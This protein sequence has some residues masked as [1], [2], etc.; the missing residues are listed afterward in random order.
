MLTITKTIEEATTANGRYRAGGTDYMDRRR[1]GLV[2]GDIVDVAELE[3]LDQIQTDDDGRTLIGAMATIFSVTS[4]PHIQEKYAGLAVAAGG[5]ATPQIRLVGTIGG[6]M[7]QRTRCQYFRHHHLKCTKK[8]DPTCGGRK[9]YHPNGIIFD[10]GG[11][12]HP[13]PSTLGMAL[14]AYEAEIEVNGRDS[15]PIFDLY[16]DGSDIGKDHLL[17]DGELIT[18]IILPVPKEEKATYFR[19]TERERAEW[20]TVECVVRLMMDGDVIGK[21]YVAVGAVGP[22]PM[23]LPQVEAALVGKEATEENFMAAAALSAE[24]ATPLRD[25]GYKVTL[26]VNTIVETLLQAVK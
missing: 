22:V 6:N 11:C 14:M 19:A 15:R 3:G 24:G 21:A 25:T 16:G 20:A 2:S 18:R 1:H 8:G 9:G 5:L 4:T 17:A 12:A 10:N 23:R 13:H 7:T 26:M